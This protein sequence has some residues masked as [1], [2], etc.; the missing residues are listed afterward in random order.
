MAAIAETGVPSAQAH[1]A[2]A[3]VARISGPKGRASGSFLA[4][5]P[6]CALRA[7]PGYGRWISA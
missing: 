7:Y 1:V 6:G 3:N 2:P 5:T 4:R